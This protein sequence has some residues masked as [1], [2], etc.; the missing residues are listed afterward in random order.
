MEAEK[1]EL[2]LDDASVEDDVK[3]LRKHKMVQIIIYES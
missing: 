3:E 2:F 1:S